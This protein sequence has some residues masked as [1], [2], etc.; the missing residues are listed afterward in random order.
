MIDSD[1]LSALSKIASDNKD[2]RAL[3]LASL[4]RDRFY[5]ECVS[6]REWLRDEAADRCRDDERENPRW[7]R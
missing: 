1:T 5:E 4:S 6:F 3:Q 2:D 7:M